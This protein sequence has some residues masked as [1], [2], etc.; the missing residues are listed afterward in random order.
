MSAPNSL[1]VRAAKAQPT[2]R[3]PVWFMRQAG[4]YMPEYRVIRKQYSLIEICK[5]PE[6][7]AQV[8]IEAAEIL[9][10]DAAIIFADL[11]LPLEVMGLPFHFAAGEGPKMENHPLDITAK[12]LPCEGLKTSEV[13]S[14]TLRVFGVGVWNNAA[15]QSL[16]S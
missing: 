8:T 10:V 6:V 7:A 9:K 3:T 1:F 16:T 15:S 5:K 14:A 12:T 2:E 11:L 13:R 4:R